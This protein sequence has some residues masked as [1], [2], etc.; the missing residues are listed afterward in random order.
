MDDGAFHKLLAQ[1]ALLAIEGGDSVQPATMLLRRY[2]LSGPVTDEFLARY[3]E[4]QLKALQSQG[5]APTS[6]CAHFQRPRSAHSL[7]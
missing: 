5:L 4:A 1:G 7:A 6:R 2:S 3:C